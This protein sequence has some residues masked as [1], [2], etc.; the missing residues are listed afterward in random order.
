MKS[1]TKTL[2]CMS[3]IFL[4]TLAYG[5]QNKDDSPPRKV[6]IGTVIHGY[7]GIKYPGLDIRLTELEELID[8]VA[9]ECSRKYPGEGLDLIVLPEGIVTR[10]K[11]RTAEAKSVV[12]EG[13]V[14]DRMSAKARQYKSNLIV[15][16]VMLEDKEKQIITNS[17]VVFDRTGAIA[18]IYRKAHPVAA[19]GS[20]S[21]E[22][23]I[24]PGSEFNVIE[25]DFGR[26]GILICYDMS[27]K[28]GWDQYAAKGVDIVA[29]PTMSPQMAAPSANALRGRYFVVTSSPR[30]NASIFNPMGMIDAQITDGDQEVTDGNVNNKQNMVLVHKIDLSYA[31]INWASKLSDGKIFT[32]KYGD[33][34]GYTYYRSEDV[35][36]FWSN[37]AEYPI[38]RMIRELGYSDRDDETERI[39]ALEDK[40]RGTSVIK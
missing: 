30:N 20:D 3:I 8:N 15:P 17:A 24:T 4:A 34:A 6:I 9:Q 2:L 22:G 25:C 35:G 7:Y 19:L 36:M 32:E 26:L 13:P 11:G 37:D 29:V 12:L 39:R 23:G 21:L 38:Q 18:G 5:D 31:L 27:Y 10:G 40:V 14:L 28:D 1:I 16:L 33:R